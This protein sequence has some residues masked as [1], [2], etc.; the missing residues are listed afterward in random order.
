MNAVWEVPPNYREICRIDMQNDKRLALL[1]NGLCLLIGIILLVP[2][3][4]FQRLYLFLEETESLA[5]YFV[6]LVV[7]L[8]SMIVYLFLHEWVHG[9]CIRYFSGKK[10]H[11]GFTGLYAF[12]ASEAYFS[13]KS[14]IVIAL[15]PIVVWGVVLTILLFCVAD[16]WFWVVYLVQVINIS[17]AA[18]DLYVTFRLS[19]MPREILVR[20]SGVMMEIYSP[21]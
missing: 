1:I 14:Y 3:L 21:E 2:L 8:V 13:K 20:D 7:L 4:F 19:K 11:Y 18:G 5:D 6:P 12:A 15:A 16:T 9:L 10:A 17:G